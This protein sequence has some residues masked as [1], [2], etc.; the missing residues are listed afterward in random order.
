MRRATRPAV[1]LLLLL[2]Y[3]AVFSGCQRTA[4]E[5]EPT[6]PL[7]RERF[8]LL[9]KV[10]QVAGKKHPEF[11]QQMAND[12][13]KAIQAG[14]DAQYTIGASLTDTGKAYRLYW[15]E[16]TFIAQEFTADDAH[17]GADRAQLRR[18]PAARP[19]AG[20]A[21]RTAVHAARNL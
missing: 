12:V 13:D 2:G 17:L 9:A 6:D 18:L 14:T 11:R 15:V 5:P 1:P 19:A 4:V 20:E 7:Q 21:G 8:R 3:L 16:Q 10:K